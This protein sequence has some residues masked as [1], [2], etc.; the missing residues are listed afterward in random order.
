MEREETGLSTSITVLRKNLLDVDLRGSS[1]VFVF[2]SPLVMR[3]LQE[4]VGREMPPGALVASVE[5]RF[6]D[7]KPTESLENV[8]LYVVPA[9]KDLLRSSIAH[10]D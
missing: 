2:L 5:H 4:K 3:R 9:P 10:Q 1:K 8:H 7:W 6:P